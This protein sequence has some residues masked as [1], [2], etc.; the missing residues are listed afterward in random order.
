VLCGT[1]KSWAE[2]GGDAGYTDAMEL[3]DLG[4]HLIGDESEE[5]S[6]KF[7]LP[8]CRGGLKARAYWCLGYTTCDS[9]AITSCSDAFS[10]LSLVPAVTIVSGSRGHPM[11]PMWLVDWSGA[12]VVSHGATVVSHG[13]NVV[14]DWSG[15][16]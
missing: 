9:P 1:A 2:D 15:A 14:V 4:L 7:S 6:Q 11:E 13:A 16:P 12:K 10:P 5:V 3:L 8:A